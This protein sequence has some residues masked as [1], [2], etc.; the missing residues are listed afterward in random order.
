LVVL[1]P[2]RI[3]FWALSE[4]FGLSNTTLSISAKVVSTV[5]SN[6]GKLG[7]LFEVRGAKRIFR[8][9]QAMWFEYH[10]DSDEEFDEDESAAQLYCCQ[11]YLLKRV[12]PTAS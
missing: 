11:Q 6:K 4:A 5:K 2:R 3:E 10:E 1:T 7:Y 12:L 9:R 8:G